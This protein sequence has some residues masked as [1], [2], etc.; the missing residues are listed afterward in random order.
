MDYK[1]AYENWLSDPMLCAEGVSELQSIADNEQEKEY[2]FS[3]ELAFGTA[4]M[5]GIIGYGTNMMNIYTVRRATKGLSDYVLS[6]GRRAAAR[7]VVISYD[8][9]N[10]SEL[11]AKTA[12][13]VLLANGIEV[14]MYS[15]PRPVPMLSFAVRELG[16]VA[17]ISVWL[18]ATNSVTLPSL[19]CSTA[20]TLSGCEKSSAAIAAAGSMYSAFVHLHLFDFFLHIIVIRLK[21]EL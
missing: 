13:G 10:F 8:T 20:F 3:T 9:R 4:G 21:V 7:G 1:I 17:G 15:Q 14:Y 16:A 11:F 2:R 19:G 5:R 12:A 18:F 6:L